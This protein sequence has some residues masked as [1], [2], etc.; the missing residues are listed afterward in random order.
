[1]GNAGRREALEYLRRLR[2]LGEFQKP[3]ITV[4]NEI[5]ARKGWGTRRWCEY[6]RW[7]ADPGMF[8]AYLV[9]IGLPFG[10]VWAFTWW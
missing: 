6:K 4:W 8:I 1:M 10:I 5:E 7:D 9:T 2:G 3:F